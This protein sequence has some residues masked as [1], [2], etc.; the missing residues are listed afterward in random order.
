MRNT[1]ADQW[2][3]IANWVPTDPIARHIHVKRV[4]RDDGARRMRRSSRSRSRM[5][6]RKGKNKSRAASSLPTRFTRIR[7]AIVFV[8]TPVCATNKKKKKVPRFAI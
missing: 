5:R 8:G 2:A 7:R 6:E 1:Y 4:G 3:Q